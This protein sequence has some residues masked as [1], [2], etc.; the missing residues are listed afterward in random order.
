MTLIK[1]SIGRPK[2]VPKGVN[3]DG[4][5][6]LVKFTDEYF[7]LYFDML[8][9]EQRKMLKE[10]VKRVKGIDVSTRS[11][12]NLKPNTIEC[13][14]RL[15]DRKTQ[16]RFILKGKVV[17]FISSPFQIKFPYEFNAP[18]TMAAKEK[19]AQN[20]NIEIECKVT[21]GSQIKK[22]NSF[23]LSV[24]EINDLKVLIK[25]LIIISFL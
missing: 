21:A 15:Y 23:S 8:T 11:F 25:Y 22:T 24:Q 19:I 12:V 14:S 2:L 4:S 13:L 1:V 20:S 9:E 16:K 17:D 3:T 5:P 18:E 10:E 7:S 6:K